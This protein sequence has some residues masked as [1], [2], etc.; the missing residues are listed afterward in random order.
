MAAEEDGGLRAAC[1]KTCAE[2]RIEVSKD[3]L[4]I[5]TTQI[6]KPGDFSTKATA[7]P[8]RHHSF[9][10]LIHDLLHKNRDESTISSFV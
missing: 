10:V 2:I 7:W 6:S 8:K 1:L 4:S 9:L 5:S 3:V